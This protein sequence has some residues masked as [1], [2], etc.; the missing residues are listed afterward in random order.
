M[1]DFYKYDETGI[2]L[3]ALPS[4]SFVW[5]DEELAGNKVLKECFTVLILSAIGIKAEAIACR[6]GQVHPYFS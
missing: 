2:F 6:L 4:K 1:E 5:Q 3:C